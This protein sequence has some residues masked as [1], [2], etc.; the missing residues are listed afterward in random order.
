MTR[1][2]PTDTAPILFLPIINWELRV[3][4]P[5][6]LARCF[7]RAGHRVYYPAL[8]LCAD[9]PPPQQVEGGIWQI[10]LRGDPG[11]DPYHDRLGSAAVEQA[12]ES[13]REISAG[14]SLEGCWIMAELPFWR[15]LAEAARTELGG[16]IVFDCMDDFSS[17]AD[18]GDVVEEERAL[19]AVADLVVVTSQK[20]YDKLAPLNPTT[21]MVRNGCDP[22][23]F[24]PAAARTLPREPVVVGFFGGIHDWF[25]AGLVADIARRRPQWEV[26]LIGDTYRGEVDELR[27]L[28]NVR[29]LGEAPYAELPRLVSGFHVGIIPFK[30]DPLTEAV[31]PVKAYEMLAAGL[32]IVSVDLPELRR[33]GP[34]VALAHDAAEFVARIEELLEEP[35]AARAQRCEAARRESWVDRFLAL[36][37]AMEESPGGTRRR[38]SAVVESF[39]LSGPFV[40]VGSLKSEIVELRQ[41]I[42][43]LKAAANDAAGER[44]SLIE[45]RDRIEAERLSLI[46]Q[47]DRVEAEAERVRGEL[48]RVE[49]ERSQLAT[50]L[51]GA[52]DAPRDAPQETGPEKVQGRR[53]TDRLRGLFGL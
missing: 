42:E 13:L 24:G 40:S 1:P 11:L 52:P 16:A 27:T 31:D 33:L 7:A 29:L 10:A 2:I 9:P 44:L 48:A 4:R 43:F 14:H 49:A 12:L 28:P 50:A 35:P 38:H 32:P 53:L 41:R 47:R 37:R 46:E 39:S 34:L 6:Q 18:H 8:R 26:R 3:Q 19:A 36:R 15:P 25:D 21:V 20:L 51:Q 45:Q 30:I 17:F 5:Q 23:H 22:V